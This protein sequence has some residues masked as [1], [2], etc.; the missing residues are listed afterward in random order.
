MPRHRSI[1]THTSLP[2]RNSPP[3]HKFQS[4]IP[5]PHTHPHPATATN[6]Q[7]SGERPHVNDGRKIYNRVP[8]SSSWPL[9][10]L[11]WLFLGMLRVCSGWLGSTHK[12]IRTFLQK[13]MQTYQKMI[14]RIVCCAGSQPLNQSRSVLNQL[15]SYK[16]K[17]REQNVENIYGQDKKKRKRK[18]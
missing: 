13:I 2:H 14:L 16:V 1:H 10:P 4:Q 17:T 12:D 8:S 3:T 11:P 6:E 5:H 7:T 9:L 18:H 15:T